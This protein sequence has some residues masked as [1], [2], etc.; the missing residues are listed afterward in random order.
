MISIELLELLKEV[1]HD[2]KTLET[3]RLQNNAFT[4]KRKMPFPSALCFMLDMRKTTLQTRLNMYFE[5]NG[6]V[7]PMSQQA[8]SKL[9]GNYDH[10]PFVTMHKAIVKKEYSGDYDLPLWNGYH[11]FGIDGSFL[12]L[13]RTEEPLSGVWYS[14][15]KASVPSRRSFRTL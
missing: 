13:P 7:E 6:K 9:R 14:R 8:F 5:H 1:I 2:H 4:R 15:P 12:Q 10:S 3:A 11:V